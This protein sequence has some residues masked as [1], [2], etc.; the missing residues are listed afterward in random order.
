MVG[1]IP[2]LYSVIASP[3]SVRAPYRSKVCDPVTAIVNR[4]ERCLQAIALGSVLRRKPEA[5]GHRKRGW[6]VSVV[7]KTADLPQTKCRV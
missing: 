7:V 3:E 6:I 1:R 2:P 5:A 4:L